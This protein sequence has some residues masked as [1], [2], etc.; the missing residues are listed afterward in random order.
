MAAPKRLVVGDVGKK[1]T[2]TLRTG[3]EIKDSVVD[4]TQYSSVTFEV[5]KP[6]PASE[7]G[8]LDVSWNAVFE[9]AKTDGKVSYSTAAND[10]DEFGDYIVT[11]KL[12]GT[13]LVHSAQAKKITVFDPFEVP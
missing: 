13:G 7:G 8:T 5:R 4:L 2:F 10:L 3:T 12:T 9:G 1:I 11:V 6:D